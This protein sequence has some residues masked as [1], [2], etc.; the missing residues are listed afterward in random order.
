MTSRFGEARRAAQPRFMVN[1]ES[2]L[3]GT[4]TASPTGRSADAGTAWTAIRA[5]FRIVDTWK[6]TRAQSAILWPRAIVQ[7]TA[8]RAP[9]EARS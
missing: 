1:D 4:T 8:G 7:R 2:S 6:L 5:F 9:R 3:H